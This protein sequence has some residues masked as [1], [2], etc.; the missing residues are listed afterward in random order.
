MKII[1]SGK[2]TSAIENTSQAI[3]TTPS[4]VVLSNGE[5]LITCRAGSTKDSSD[6]IIELYRSVDMGTKWTKEKEPF[7]NTIVNGLE[8]TIKI[9]YLT[10]IVDGHIIAAC[11][12]VDRQS[13]PGKPLFNNKTEGCLPMKILLADSY[14][15]GKTWA[16]LREVRMPD[17]IGPPSLTSPILKLKDGTLGMSIETNKHYHDSSKWYQRV[18]MFYSD[19]CGKN[20]NKQNTIAK[21]PSGKIFNWDL[22]VAVSPDGR[23]VAFSWYYDSEK[24]KYLNI[25]RLISNDNGLTWSKHEDLG[26][27]D[28][29]SH[30]AILSDGQILL[31][32]VDRFNSRTIK[33]RI[34]SDLNKPFEGNTE[35]VLYRQEEFSSA[36]RNTGELLSEMSLWNFG[37]P[38]AEKL[39]DENVMVLYYAGTNEC[40]DIH[41]VL[42]N[43]EIK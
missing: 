19:D 8:G 6:E 11:M 22:R 37:L 23:L 39:P 12:W 41:W 4:L 31:A 14:D 10:E 26:I 27:T 21:D 20:W 25:Q 38:Y 5:L 42:I 35:L 16:P 32:W 9:C 7:I 36:S 40:M 43:L 24:N 1:K 29:P 28:Q 2:I 15:Y 34:A 18:V 17:E 13:Y 3:Y 33:A 30:P